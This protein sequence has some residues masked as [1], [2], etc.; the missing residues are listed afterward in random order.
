MIE[1]EFYITNKNGKITKTI[2]PCDNYLQAFRISEL[3]KPK[4]KCVW[5]MK[6]SPN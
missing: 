1:F 6:K 4:Y 5:K 3:L 2:I